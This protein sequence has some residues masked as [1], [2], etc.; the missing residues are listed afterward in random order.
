MKSFWVVLIT[1]C[2]LGA[3][4]LAFAFSGRYNVS[5]R[6]PHLATTTLLLEAVRDRSI[7]HY[8]SK[9][10]L[11]PP[12]APAAAMVG[13]V[14]FDATCRKC[15]GAPGMPQ[16]EFAEGLYPKPPSLSESTRDLSRKEIFWV[17][18]NGLKMTGM[19]A[20]G[21]NHERDEIIAM[22][23]FIEKLP[24][25]DTQGYAQFVQ[26]AKAHG[27]GEG[28][29]HSEPGEEMHPDE[30]GGHSHETESHHH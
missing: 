11:P 26:Q 5:A 9:I 2:V 19:P 25:L 22:A 21:G 23:A 16:E 6:V 4:A 13:A 12:A 30:H 29:H 27:G 14:H 20:F 15:H 1:I 7:A 8:S 18:E 17:I 24:E 28:H 10:E 3:A